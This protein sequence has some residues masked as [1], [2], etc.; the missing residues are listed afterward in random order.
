LVLPEAA[1]HGE[2]VRGL[3]H[4]GYGETAHAD[5]AGFLLL[6]EACLLEDVEMFEDGG[7]GDVVRAGEL[8]D[9]SVPALKSGEDGPTRGV[10]E[11]GEGGVEIN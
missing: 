7:H 10:T 9:G 2:P 3:L 1:I 8:G 6:D 5:T 4:G 11:G